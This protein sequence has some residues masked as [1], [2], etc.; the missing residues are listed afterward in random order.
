VITFIRFKVLLITLATSIG[1]SA[2]GADV[3]AVVSAK[4]QVMALN[5]N[6]ISDIFLG[7][8][9]TF[10]NGGQAVP[11][12]LTEGTPARD[13]FYA[14][15]TGKSAAQI[16]AHWSKIIFTGRGLPPKEVLNGNEVK[17]RLAENPNAISYIDQTMV[18][19]SVRVLYS[20]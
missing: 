5:P 12:D 2:A 16:K 7:K 9:N 11:I 14:N 1:A 4:S 13:E 6:Q 19:S 8:T 10:P 3:V 17:R 20:P 15:L 18:D